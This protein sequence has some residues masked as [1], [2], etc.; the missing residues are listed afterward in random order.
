[1]TELRSHES[2]RGSQRLLFALAGLALLLR[3]LSLLRPGDAWTVLDDSREYLALV[4]GMHSGCGFARMFDGVCSS[5]ELL[6]LP[7]YPFFVAILP[8]LRAVVALQA[9]VG[10][11][12]CLLI[13]L[14]TCKRW[15]LPAGVIAETLL[16]LDIPSIVASSTIMSD[17]LFEATLALAVTLQLS[18]IGGGSGGRRPIVLALLAAAFLAFAV[19]LRAVAIVLPIFAS[20]PFLLMP[21]LAPKKRLALCLAAILIPATAIFAWTARNYLRTGRWTFTTE[22]AYNLYY[23]NAAG[24]LWYLH[25]GSLT[26]LQDRLAGAIGA[27]GPDE[28]VSPD[29]QRQMLA[30]GAS[31]LLR[32]PVAALAMLV[33]CFLWLAIVPDRANLNA[34]LA[35][36][37]RSSVFLV[38]SQNVALR[39]RETLR[40][41]LL[42]ALVALQVPLIIFTWVGV[43][44][45]LA[46]HSAR[47]REELALILLPLG[48]A[49]AMMLAATGPG[50][51]ARFRMPAMPF[52]AMLAGAGWSETVARRAGSNA[53]ASIA[54]N[55]VVRATVRA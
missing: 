36:N 55:L 24:V 47:T 5:P 16:A 6:R 22:A 41:P 43:A 4:R 30:R 28:F 27:N 44:L 15:G 25:G 2:D 39:V 14:F 31:V 34:L 50:A 12:T 51:I 11:A 21:R 45:M 40:S 3:L 35:T 18:A 46:Q 13:G 53:F 17:C 26:Q 19:L 32:H 29:Q 8:N 49:V 48:V 9:A 23:Y 54:P 37:A 20:V 33:R 10:A 52:L 42:S 7:G 38:A 1:M